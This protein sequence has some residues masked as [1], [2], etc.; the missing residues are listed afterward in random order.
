MERGVVVPAPI[1]RRRP[2]GRRFRLDARQR[3]AK[4]LTKGRKAKAPGD[5]VQIDTLFVN[6]RPDKAIKHFTAYDP[7]AKWTIGH[8]ASAASA[9]AARVL[10]DKLL[11]SAPLQGWRH[12]GRRRIGVHVR[13]RGPL[14]HQGPRARRPAAQAPR[15]QWL[16]RARP[17][18]LE[19]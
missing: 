8:V 1:L 12:P 19:I 9:S 2:G 18:E 11:S 6:V 10:L 14:P 16:R 17:V 4:R 3:Y 15:P 7:V 5:L 13:L